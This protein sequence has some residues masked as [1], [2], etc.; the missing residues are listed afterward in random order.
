MLAWVDTLEAFHAAMS[1]GEVCRMLRWMLVVQYVLLR[2]PPRGGRRG[3]D[4]VAQ[5]FK[6]W[7][8]GDLVKLVKWWE[9]DRAA[10]H[11]PLDS[12]TPADEGKEVERA[13]CL[14]AEGEIGRAARLLQSS[15]L[16]DLSDTRVIEQLKSKHPR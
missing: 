1:D 6:A 11:R 3:H 14:I 8:D 10:A 7:Q 4:Q 15:G 13:L 16:G 12:K 9:R 5:R 2:L